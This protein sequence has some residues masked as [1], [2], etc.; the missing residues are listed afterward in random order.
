MTRFRLHQNHRAIALSAGLLAVLSLL[1]CGGGDGSATS[2]PSTPPPTTT[3]VSGAVVKGPVVAA[4][5]CAYAVTAGA[6]GAALGA[7]TTTDA[8]GNYSF[9]V[10]AGSGPLWVQATGGSYVDEASG[11]TVTLPAGSPL[12]SLVTANGAAVTTMLTPLTTLALNTARASVGTTGSLDAAAFAAAVAQ[13]QTAFNLPSTF[14]LVTTAPTFGSTPNA[15]GAA[16]INIS[17]MVAAGTTLAQF[18]AATQPATLATAYA[19]AAAP[20]PTP[21]VAGAPLVISAATPASWNGTLGITSAQF[22]HG[23]SSSTGGAPYDATQAYCRVAAYGLVNSGDNTA[24][25]LQIPF[26]KDNRD[27][28]LVQFGLDATLVTLARGLGP[29]P[30]MVIDTANRRITFTNVV[31]GVGATSSFTLN[32]TLTYPTNVD[33]SNRAACG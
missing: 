14:S 11:T 32:G 26:R 21:P 19:A 8:N 16:L 1:G 13:L 4:Q 9:S 2:N 28:G 25:F 33:P 15:Y 22:E 17:R 27:V 20:A 29:L 5:V 6:R 10:P 31:I 18:L 30:G 23:S 12:I 3:M 7:C 24:Y